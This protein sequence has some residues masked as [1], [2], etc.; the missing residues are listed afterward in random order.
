[1]CTDILVGWVWNQMNEYYF[2]SPIDCQQI[3]NQPC[4][5]YLGDALGGAAA[6]HPAPGGH[7]RHAQQQPRHHPGD[8]THRRSSSLPAGCGAACCRRSVPAGTDRARRDVVQRKGGGCNACSCLSRAD[9][10]FICSISRRGEAI[11]GRRWWGEV[12]VVFETTRNCNRIA[13]LLLQ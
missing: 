10:L 11:E 13:Y 2:N 3:N 12:V 5:R 1:M 6:H 4:S 9:N 8:E 7:E